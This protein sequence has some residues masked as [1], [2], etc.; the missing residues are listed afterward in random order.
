MCSN[1]FGRSRASGVVA[2]ECSVFLAPWD[3]AKIVATRESLQAAH[4]L[5]EADI[6]QAIAW[7]ERVEAELDR[8]EAGIAVREGL[9]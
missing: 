1:G 3:R 6:S 2:G 8:M 5:Q 7:L 9:A 4:D